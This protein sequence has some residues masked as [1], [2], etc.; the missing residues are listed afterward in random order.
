MMSSSNGTIFRVTGLVW[1]ES[2]VY[3]QISITKAIHVELWCFLWATPEQTVEQIIRTLVI[4]DAIALLMTSQYWRRTLMHH[5]NALHT[6]SSF[7]PIGEILGSIVNN[8]GKFDPWYNATQ[9]YELLHVVNSSQFVAFI[10][11]RWAV[12]GAVSWLLGNHNWL[13]GILWWNWACNKYCYCNLFFIFVRY[14][15]Q[16]ALYVQLIWC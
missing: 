3:R 11:W 14:K 16:F 1:G 2:T 8:L 7:T 4:W 12:V 6:H 13:L 9:P 15:V 10:W 5:L